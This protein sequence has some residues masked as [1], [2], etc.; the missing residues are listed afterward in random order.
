[1]PL[2]PSAGAISMEQIR[3]EFGG[4]GAVSLSQFY[5]NGGLVSDDVF[6]HNN[7]IPASGPISF[8]NFHGTTN[9]N[10]YAYYGAGGYN[11]IPPVNSIRSQASVGAGGGGGC[12]RVYARSAR[13]INNVI[14][15]A[16]GGGGGYSFATLYFNKNAGDFINLSIGGGAGGAGARSNDVGTTTSGGGGGTT[17]SA[18]NSSN[19]VLGSITA[20]GGGGASCNAGSGTGHAYA[21]GGG[22]GNIASGG[23]GGAAW[24]GLIYG[25]RRFDVGGGG[26]GGGFG[27]GGG[28]ANVEFG[29]GSAGTGGAGRTTLRF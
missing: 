25:R 1:M 11:H 16:G 21:G 2:P 4:T 29:G 15:C 27:G 3:A 12:W 8:A 7:T 22:W 20:N 13:G 24:N 28:A 17:A 6:C 9:G 26:G 23:G 18:R 10:T 19:V 5:R 14:S